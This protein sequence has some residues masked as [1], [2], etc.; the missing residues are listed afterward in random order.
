M[1]S[2][3][4][5]SLNLD[6]IR[7]HVTQLLNSPAREKLSQIAKQVKTQSSQSSSKLPPSAM[8]PGRTSN[9]SSATKSNIEM[10]H[11]MLIPND[12]HR[13]VELNLNTDK[14]MEDLAAELV[15]MEKMKDR[16]T[17]KEG[18]KLAYV[19]SMVKVSVDLEKIEI[20]EDHGHAVLHYNTDCHKENSRARTEAHFDSEEFSVT[21]MNELLIER[22]EV[23]KK[24]ILHIESSSRMYAEVIEGPADFKEIAISNRSFCGKAFDKDEIVMQ[25]LSSE[26]DTNEPPIYGCVVGI[27][28]RF[29]DPNNRLFVCMAEPQ[30]TGVMIPINRGIQK[31][32]NLTS[33]AKLKRAMKG[34]V[35]VYHF[36]KEEGVRFNRY[37]KIDPSNP[38][39]KLF[40]VHYLKWERHMLFPVGVVIGVIPA[41]MDLDTGMQILE[42]EYNIPRNFPVE[43]LSTVEQK[44]PFDFQFEPEV[45]ENRLDIRDKWTFTID[46]AA[47]KDLSNAL[48]IEE[49]D[50]GNYIVGVHVSDVGYFIEK[51]DPVDVEAERRGASHYPLNHEA[52]HMLPARISTDLCSLKTGHDRLTISLFL[53]VTK[54]GEIIG[55]EPKKC[56]MSSK[57]RFTIQDTEAIIHDS[58]ANNDYFKSCILVLYQIASVWRRQ[59]LGNAHLY[60]EMDIEEKL[61]PAAVLM[62]QE[63]TL[64]ANC[65]IAQMLVEEFPI[66]VPLWCQKPPNDVALSEWKTNYASDAVNSIALTKP[67]LEGLSTCNCKVACGCIGKFMRQERLTPKVEFDVYSLL[68]NDVVQTA[69][70][71]DMSFVQNFIVAADSHPQISVALYN[72]NAIQNRCRYQCSGDTDM[73]SQGHY[74]MNIPHYVHFTN[75]LQR[76]MDIVVQRLVSDSLVSKASSY[77]SQDIKIICSQQTSLTLQ[78]TQFKNAVQMLHLSSAL[79]NR[80]LLL[81]PI[82]EKA[83]A[84]GI[85]LLFPS[86]PT[87]P[88]SSKDIDLN[89]LQFSEEP[90]QDGEEQSI[91]IKWQK[92]VYDLSESDKT[93][94]QRSIAV[95][96]PEQFILKMPSLKWQLLMKAVREEN[97][98]KLQS[99]VMSAQE[100]IQ[101][102]SSSSSFAVEVSSERTKSGAFDHYAQFSRK[103]QPCTVLR[104]QVSAK[105]MKGI[106]TPHLQLLNLTPKLDICLEHRSDPVSCFANIRESIATNFDSEEEYVCAWKAVVSME[107]AK[108]TICNGNSITIHNLQLK[109]QL[110][111]ASKKYQAMFTIPVVFLKERQ[112]KSFYHISFDELFHPKNNDICQNFFSDYL[113][114]RYNDITLA[115][116]PALNE[117]IALIVNNS[118]PF[119]WIGH[120]VI[121]DVVRREN[122]LQITATLQQSNVPLPESLLSPAST[123]CTVEWICK[124]ER[125]R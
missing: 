125:L 38:S 34:H 6:V 47:S 70:S 18:S 117:S 100:S 55:A 107:T 22:P 39:G 8:N 76:Y 2:L 123:S 44:F 23:Y 71:N 20:K 84:D 17:T 53:T 7:Q 79:R 81:Y 86:L 33:E 77:F 109:W 49:E 14:I 73:D 124:P 111:S 75:P 41:G 90:V 93:P 82:I 72:W 120:C 59:R 54:S 104:I 91:D 30:T 88:A 106:V 78:A 114:F 28:N 16:L 58:D 105:L 19:D 32:Y 108:Q 27:L 43:A 50:E 83:S 89:L 103:F 10:P 11:R 122:H 37:E 119:C 56:V 66:C 24:C 99:A 87:L 96:N 61:T 5:S 51:G 116:D 80:P 69:E 67:F 12:Q 4:P 9:L 40:I 31:I 113:C 92:R 65:K 42:I 102:P 45:Y 64:M 15:K 112:M 13:S 48:S 25:I 101:D 52:V 121:T 3:H 85:H 46:S 95:L 26:N 1:N 68:W 115:D 97:M 21:R 110:D 29:I 62:I 98:E 118:V 57:Q 94:K 60:N 35:C 74:V 63:I 36:S